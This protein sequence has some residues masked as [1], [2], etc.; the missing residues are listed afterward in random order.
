MATIHDAL[1]LAQK[2]MAAR[3]LTRAQD[4]YRKIVEIDPT[5]AQAWF[6]LGL[7]NQLSNRL[8][9]SELD[10][11]EALRYEPGHREALNNLGIGLHVQGK[12]REAIELLREAVGLHPGHP[13][14]HSNLGNALQDDGRLDDAIAS[15]RQAL[16]LNPRHFDAQNNLGNALRGQ[17]RLAESV[18]AY[19]Q[20]LQLKPDDPQV[21]MSQALCWLQ[22]GDFE[23]GWEA[24][25]WRLKC[26]DYSIPPFRKPFWEGE[27]LE[28]RTILLHADHGFGDS[29]QFIR[30]AETVKA[31]GGHLIVQCQRSLA[32]LL[33][34][35]P[36]IDHVI[37]ESAA[38]PEFDCYAPLMSLPRIFDTRLS[39]VPADVPYLSPDRALRERWAREL[40]QW[41]GFRVGIAWQGNPRHRRDRQRSFRLARFE[42]LVGISSAPFF[43]LQKGAGAEQIDEHGG[44]VPVIDLGGRCA[45]F[46]DS[47]AAIQNLDL[48]ITCDSAVAHLAGALGI[49]TWL[50]IGFAPDWRWLT[51]RDDN[52]WYPSMRLFRQRTWGDWDEVFTRIAAA[53]TEAITNR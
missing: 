17:G 53:L 28:G 15:Y 14:A 43:S 42:P 48:V 18:A 34:S 36:A 16:T 13:D 23:R 46:M 41:K 38:L 24:Y 20:A 12:T 25:E 7:I 22:M 19:E 50:A 52:P 30:Y 45:D 40:E 39:S 35:C 32:R 10:Y 5:Q 37:T 3:D 49:P 47:A 6:F 1:A 44:R 51:T 27:P 31:R 26:P 8:P 9:E 11:R 4:L 2:L 33:L 21:H 29:I